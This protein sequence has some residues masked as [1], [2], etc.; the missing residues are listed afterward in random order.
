MKITPIP[1]AILNKKNSMLNTIPP[2]MNPKIR[3]SI[4]HAI[5][6]AFIT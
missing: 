2:T 4:I 1:R 3:I 5:V 6:L